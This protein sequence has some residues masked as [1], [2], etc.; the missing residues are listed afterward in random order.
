M[1]AMNPF[2]KRRHDLLACRASSLGGVRYQR[3]REYRC[4]L[5]QSFARAGQVP[6]KAAWFC[7]S[8]EL[9][10]VATLLH[11][12]GAVSAHCGLSLSEWRFFWRA[13][14]L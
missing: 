4:K 7:A 5:S 6:C 1:L 13:T 2:P 8:F 14:R 9:G 12:T 3:K 11:L 10:H